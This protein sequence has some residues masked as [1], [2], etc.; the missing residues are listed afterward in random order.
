[1]GYLIDAN[2]V[3]KWGISLQL[4]YNAK[5]IPEWQMAKNIWFDLF[6]FV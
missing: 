2:T 5:M 4:C 1:M 6:L 3:K